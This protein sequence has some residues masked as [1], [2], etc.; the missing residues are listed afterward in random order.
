LA[1]SRNRSV[2]SQGPSTSAGARLVQLIL[3]LLVL[4]VAA[5]VVFLG[6]WDLPAPSQPVER[7]IPNDRF[8][9]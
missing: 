2:F 7:V 4:A 5:G 3:V 8:G 9:Q 1:R 6:V